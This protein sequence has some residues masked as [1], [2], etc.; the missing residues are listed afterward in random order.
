[1]FSETRA[2]CILAGSGR[3]VQNERAWP[4]LGMPSGAKTRLESRGRY[5]YDR[6][7]S[8][9]PLDRPPRHHVAPLSLLCS[10]TTYNVAHGAARRPTGS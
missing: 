10:T 6:R 9:D 4:V 2:P 7:A 1:M 5:L 8:P 3:I